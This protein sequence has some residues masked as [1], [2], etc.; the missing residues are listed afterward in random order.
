MPALTT[1]QVKRSIMTVIMPKFTKP[2]NAK[3]ANQLKYSNIF[4]HISDT[5]LARGEVLSLGTAHYVYLIVQGMVK[6]DVLYGD[7]A[8]FDDYTQAGEFINS[9]ILFDVAARPCRCT[10]LLDDTIVKKI[11]AYL[12]LQE[13][14]ANEALLQSLMKDWINISRRSKERAKSLDLLN[15]EQRVIHFL[16]RYAE[17]SGRKVGFDLMVKPWLTHQEI[18]Q[19]AGTSRQTTTSVLNSLRREG[20]IHFTRRYL[21]IRDLAKLQDL[22]DYPLTVIA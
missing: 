20:L 15:S 18:S 7:E 6:Q 17:Q 9:E 19:I 2:A 13:A 4:E 22:L 3:A 11:P 1:N 16:I 5:G 8:L 12:F 10:V 14:R 21:L